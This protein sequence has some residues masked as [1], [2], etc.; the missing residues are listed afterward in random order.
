[1][2]FSFF[3]FELHILD[4]IAFNCTSCLIL[5]DFYGFYLSIAEIPLKSILFAT[6][7]FPHQGFNWPLGEVLG[8]AIHRRVCVSKIKTKF[9]ITNR[10]PHQLFI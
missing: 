7:L 4:T 8:A 3:L 9:S 10:I 5:F 2:A 1:M 6:S